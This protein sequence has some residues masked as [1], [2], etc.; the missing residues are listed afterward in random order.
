MGCRRAQCESVSELQ[1]ELLK[2]RTA[3]P[4]TKSHDGRLAH[5]DH[6][7]DL[8]EGRA[9]NAP[10]VRQHQV[11]YLAFGFA[12]VVVGGPRRLDDILPQCPRSVFVLQTHWMRS[13]GNAANLSL[14]RANTP[15]AGAHGR[16]QTAPCQ[17]PHRW[18]PGQPC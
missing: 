14:G 1:L 5:L 2:T 17:P 4:R 11:G 9:K 13:S 16:P 6:F 18:L 12:Q 8:H 15:P 10:R 3:D 7:G